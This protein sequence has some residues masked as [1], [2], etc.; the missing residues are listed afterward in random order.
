MHEI[1]KLIDDQVRKI[2]PKGH[3]NSLRAQRDI[4]AIFLVGGFGENQYLKKRIEKSFPDI[5]VIQPNKAW[6]AIVKFVWLAKM[7]H[8]LY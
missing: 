8:R 1:L 5:Q 6:E 2:R 7:L 4:K 3:G